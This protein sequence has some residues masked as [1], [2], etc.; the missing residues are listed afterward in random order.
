MQFSMIFLYTTAC[1]LGAIIPG[2]T[3]L[4]A[5]A[6]ETSRNR[7]VVVAGMLEAAALELGQRVNNVCPRNGARIVQGIRRI[8]MALSITRGER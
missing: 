1:F 8:D 2:P 5:M 6:N 3:S 7:R 4:L